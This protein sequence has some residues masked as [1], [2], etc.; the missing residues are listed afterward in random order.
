[1]NVMNLKN[2]NY[3]RPKLVGLILFSLLLSFSL[4]IDSREPRKTH[5]VKS[6]DSIARISDFY[7][8]SQRDLRELN[9]LGS[10]TSI[11]LGQ[12]LRI[13]NVLRVPGKPYQIQQG[14]SLATIAKKHKCSAKDIA[15]AN[16]ITP[17]SALQTGRTLVIPNPCNS[18][19]KNA[20]SFKQSRRIQFLRVLTGESE[21]LRLYYKSGK[22]NRNSVQKLSYLARYRHGKQPVKRLNS[23]LIQMIQQVAEKFP[24]ATVEII[25][26]YRP[27]STG[28]ETQ[29]AFGRAL[30][31]RLSG[32]SPK[33][34]FNFC[35]SLPLS[36]CGY[37]PNDGF[38]HMDAREKNVAWIGR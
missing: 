34:V 16:K 17:K 21:R 18:H 36:G 1:M 35:K 31:F 5:V 30:D 22:I 7:G 25:S 26:G 6:G 11:R 2:E 23:R 8:V 37:Y 3:T 19:K 12:T 28:N 27:Q 24:N 38:V 9:K 10:K 33:K 20:T 29:H 14:D 13:P 4:P 15:L 32:V